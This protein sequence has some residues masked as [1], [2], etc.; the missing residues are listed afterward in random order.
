M[1][2]KGNDLLLEKT[3]D[4]DSTCVDGLKRFCKDQKVLDALRKNVT[5]SSVVTSQRA[6]TIP[7]WGCFQ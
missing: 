3:M 1:K 6:T 2:K 4:G 5:P 7:V